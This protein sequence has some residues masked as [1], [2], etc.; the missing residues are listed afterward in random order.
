MEDHQFEPKLLREHAECVLAAAAGVGLALARKRGREIAFPV[1][2]LFTDSLVHV[3]HRPWWDYYYLH[4]AVPLAWLAGWAVNELIQDILRLHAKYRF[5]LSSLEGKRQWA[6]CLLVALVITRSEL[7]LE[8]MTKDLRKHPSAG[9]NPIV[10]KMKEY[11]GRT[12]LAYS[13]SGLYTF[14]ARLPT[15]PELAVVTLK[16]FWSGQVTTAGII[17]I[18]RHKQ[19]EMLVLPKTKV[20]Q[21]WEAFLGENYSTA[22]R[23]DNS[24]LFVSK[25]IENP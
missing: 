1:A 23:D 19:I 17:E 12:H 16:R 25:Q 18:C 3:V 24:V 4:L 7:R 21:E 6:L 15:P 5:K 14:H 8:W 11:A 13:E 2:L 20:T 22:A 10:A 9:T